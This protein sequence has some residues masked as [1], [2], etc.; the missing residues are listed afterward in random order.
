MSRFKRP[1]PFGKSGLTVAILALVLAMVGGAY[2]AGKLT[3]GQKKE[4][5]KIAKKYAGKPGPAGAAGPAGP[6]G[7]NG[8]K[9][10]TG[11]KGPKGDTGAPGENGKSVKAEQAAIAECEGEGGTKFE[12]QDSGHSETVCNGKEGPPGPE[13]NIKSTLPAGMSEQGMWVAPGGPENFS[14]TV[15]ARAAVSFVIPLKTE[16]TVV[17]VK[18]GQAGVEHATECPATEASQPK[19]AEG[20]LCVYAT[21]EPALSGTSF[22]EFLS[23]ETTKS[24]AVLEFEGNEVEFPPSSG[25]KQK[26]PGFYNQGTWAVTGN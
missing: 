21:V 2:A 6:A 13:G 22:Y 16:P 5:E 24:G 9:G 23:A 18:A 12:V 20:F 14:H 17:Y 3:S 19:A 7:S 25:T 10:A 11:E 4:V 26:F 1:E 15:S 8:E